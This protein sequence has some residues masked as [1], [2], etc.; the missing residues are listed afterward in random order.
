M[1]NLR[2]LNKLIHSFDEGSDVS[3]FLP[4]ITNCEDL[5]VIS[6]AALHYAIFSGIEEEPMK[7]PRL[8]M[9]LIN[10]NDTPTQSKIG[11]FMALLS[12]ADKRCLNFIHESWALMRPTEQVKAMTYSSM[13]GNL[14]AF[15]FVL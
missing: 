13:M 15:K 2:S 4:F 11:I 7:G 1:I 5:T 8:L 10:C 14:T 6:T 3:D 9:E 12:F